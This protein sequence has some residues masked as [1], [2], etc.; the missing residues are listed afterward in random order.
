[1]A[2]ADVEDTKKIVEEH[3]GSIQVISKA[4]QGTT[5]RI[6]LPMAAAPPADR[7][8]PSARE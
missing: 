8:K 7:S 4:G 1:M 6:R 2:D 5:F 3:N